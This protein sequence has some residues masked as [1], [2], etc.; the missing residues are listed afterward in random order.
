RITYSGNT[1]PPMPPDEMV[2]LKVTKRTLERLERSA[3]RNET[4][5]DLINRL[6]DEH[7]KHRVEE[8]ERIQETWEDI[9]E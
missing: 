2:T 1:M 6:I 8:R 9:H 5:N 4:L 7:D 3:R